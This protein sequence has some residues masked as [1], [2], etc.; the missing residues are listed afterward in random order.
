M[1]HWLNHR[2]GFRQIVEAMLLEHI[3]GGAKWRYVWGS[4][5]AFVFAT[6]LIT[7]VLLMTAYSPGDSTAW[8]SVYFI[9]YEMDFGWLIRGLHHFGSQTMVVLLGIHM[10]QVVIA[11]A[12][13]PPREINWW[14]GLALM[15]VVLGLSLTG[16]LLPWDQ[17]GFFATQVATNILG[18]LPVIG[19]FLQKVVV[20]GPVYGHHTLTHFYALHVGILPP[21]LIV[22]L[23]AHIAIFRRHGITAPKNAQ[24]EGVFWPDQA[25][26]DLIVCLL[27]FGVMLG[28][29]VFSGHG[30]KME[31]APEQ[32]DQGLYQRVA[33]AGKAGL[34]A[35]LD[36]PADPLTE[37]Y[38]A[39]P[40]WYFLFLFQLLKYFEGEQFLIGA[41]V[42]PNAVAIVLFLLPLFGYGK[43]RPFGHFLGI[44]VVVSL[45]IGV[46]LLTLLALADD[47]VK[48]FPLGLGGGTE[49]AKDLHHRFE[50]AEAEA[51][52]AVQ[53]ASRG[54][55]EEGA[56]YLLR[57]D[58]LTRG[59]TLFAKYCGVCHAFSGEGFHKNQG[60]HKAGD[61]AGFATET[62]IRSLLKNPGDNKFFGLTKL[63]GMK[64]W[65]AKV[66]KTR[67][68]WKKN[69]GP[70]EAD[71]KIAEQEAAF[72]TIA[73]WL[74]D[75]SRPKKQRDLQLEV[76]G[77]DLFADHC[78]SCHSIHGEGGNIGPDFTDYGSENWI[79]ALVMD[80]ANPSRYGKNNQMPAFR[81]GA[82]P[83]ADILRQEFLQRHEKNDIKI[84]VTD[85][86]DIDRELIIRWLTHDDRVVFGGK[87][88]TGPLKEN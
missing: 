29:V 23:I 62:W 80:P 21:L 6:Q 37:G 50:Q 42:I 9:Q 14:L 33:Q 77:K 32:A 25:F 19:P 52:R 1:A 31:T 53:L 7:G 11:G 10:L 5:L 88:V 70:A 65:R 78:A 15:G 71:K 87:T 75:Q 85:L 20:G 38:P 48:P 34:G 84:N 57:G 49:K 54:I 27:I 35:N 3:P 82:G 63:E 79:R 55:P 74:A 24:G 56:R 26:R 61:L 67:E 18:S 43:M 40:E 51:G 36:A 17:K 13:L 41:V 69:D 72:D 4:T 22:L 16:Y 64:N 81:I 60:P 44:V 66:D 47:S 73:R 39:R 68:K 83:G 76:K 30:N 86:S 8:G 46:G 58:P 45:L 2:I 12:Q 59:P 28:L